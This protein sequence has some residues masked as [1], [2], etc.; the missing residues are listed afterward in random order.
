MPG[1]QLKG[2]KNRKINNISCFINFLIDEKA[3]VCEL[4]IF[5]RLR[6][7]F[8][9]HRITDIDLDTF[10]LDEELSKIKLEMSERPPAIVEPES[11][12]IRER[13]PVAKE[14]IAFLKRKL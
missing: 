14:E 9:T 2:V 3:R 11:P 1:K 7:G 10:D 8:I 4:E 13:S 5:T 6:P 12:S